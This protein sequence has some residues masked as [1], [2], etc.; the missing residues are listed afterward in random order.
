MSIQPGTPAP[1]TAA[2]PESAA[3]RRGPLR[4]VR[5]LAGPILV[6]VLLIGGVA[7]SMLDKATP[8]ADGPCRS[9]P[10]TVAALR[11]EAVF[12]QHP[13]RGALDMDSESFSCA[14]SSPSTSVLTAVSSGVVSRRLTTS[15]TP[16]QV[17]SYYAGLAERTGWLS[18]KPAVGLYSASK[19]AGDCPWWFVVT[20]GKR[21]YH[22]MLHYRPIGDTDCEWKTD[23]ELIIPVAD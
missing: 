10:E 3:R 12:T 22:V 4:W 20:A 8:A 9:R 6:T 18:D 7:Y 1:A 13:T 21:G 2:A 19:P 5:V 17:R 14:G 23:R 16:A 11:A 15:M